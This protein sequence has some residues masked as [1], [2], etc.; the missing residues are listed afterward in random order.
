M[1]K[2]SEWESNAPLVIAHRGASAYAPENT[3][4]AILEAVRMRANAIELDA[5]LLK[6]GSIIV[7]HDTTLDRTTNGQG[8]I[9]QYTYDEIRGLD[10]GS[11]FSPQFSHENIPTLDII[12]KR[13][14][15]DLLFNIELTNYVRPWD[16]LPRAVITLVRRYQL[17][18]SVLL[19]SFNP[20]ALITSKR[21]EPGIPIALL[22]HPKVSRFLRSFMQKIIDPMAYHPHHS[23]VSEEMMINARKNNK[24]V[25]VWTVN[26]RLKM[27]ELIYLGVNG[28]ITDFPDIAEDVIRETQKR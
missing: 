19:S 28:L 17:E 8:S 15:E 5:K 9:Y 27:M 13:F 21:I 11:N 12:L 23:C 20:W 26:E 18:K 4:A 7:L 1:I 14:G 16:G 22:F 3:L 10:A 6:D 24:R 25:N 2:G